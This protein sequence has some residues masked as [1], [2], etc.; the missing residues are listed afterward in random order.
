MGEYI[1]T[2]TELY[3]ILANRPGIPRDCP[4]N[5]PSVPASRKLTECPGI[6][7]QLASFPGTRFGIIMISILE[8]AT[9]L[10]E[11]REP[12]VVLRY[13]QNFQLLFPN[14]TFEIQ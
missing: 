7:C 13:L 6:A 10:G 11:R 4:G 2:K 8:N 5:C 9:E 1:G 12:H 14:L 3:R